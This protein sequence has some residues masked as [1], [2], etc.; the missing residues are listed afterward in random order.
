MSPGDAARRPAHSLRR[1]LLVVVLAAIALASLLQAAVAWRAA[2]RQADA[3]FDAQL[4]SVARMVQ[5]GAWMGP[6]GGSGSVDV[7]V[8]ILGPDGARVFGSARLTLPATPVLGFSEMRV[9]GVPYRVYSVQTASHTIQI[10]QDLHA[11]RER[12][13]GLAIAAALPV[14][15]LAPLLMLA[16]GWLINQSLRPVER[17]RAQVARRPAD[18][19]SALPEQGLPL[20][21]LPLVQELNLLF[22]RVRL[23]FEAQQHFVA[24]AAHELRSPLAAIRLQAQSLRRPQPEA[25]RERSVAQLNAGVERAIALAEQLLLLAREEGG[26]APQGAGAVQLLALAGD[27]IAQALPQARARGIDL[28]L[29][30]GEPA[31]VRGDAEALAALLR[32]LLENA[33]KYTPAPGQIDVSVFVDDGRAA[34]VVEDSGPG[35]EE[36]ERERVFDRFYRSSA[37]RGDVSGSGLGLAIVRAVAQRHGA[38]V[39]LDR[40]Q[41]LGGL[42]A[43]VDFPRPEGRL[44]Q[45]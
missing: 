16:V 32:N 27:A 28:G 39:R 24:D 3:L 34:L 7:Q 43:R 6:E 26:G 30:R 1:R 5:A 35:I 45:A 11:R 9:Q 17:V 29:A 25:E 22:A 4:Q 33:L 31:E 21:V 23:A 14:A 19:L 13:R 15:A 18:D 12:A 36:G 38:Q 8:Q 20:E 37:A 41:R 2:L 42:A 10:A 40:S 44:S